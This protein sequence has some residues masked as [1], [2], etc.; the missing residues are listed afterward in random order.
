VRGDPDLLRDLGHTVSYTA[1]AMTAI[2]LLFLVGR[3]PAL[4]PAARHP[5]RSAVAHRRTR[6]IRDDPVPR[7]FLAELAWPL[8]VTR[9]PRHLGGVSPNRPLA[10]WTA[11][12]LVA[13]Q[14]YVNGWSVGGAATPFGGTKRSAY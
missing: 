12:R 13:G 10:H 14:I 2:R 3:A 1:L 11:D 5:R 7:R 4:G 6:G 8:R 9:L